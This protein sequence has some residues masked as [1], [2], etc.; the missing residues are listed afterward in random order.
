MKGISPQIIPVVFQAMMHQC[1]EGYD[2]EQWLEEHGVRSR[3]SPQEIWLL[4]CP[5]CGH[6]TYYDRTETAQCA[7]CGYGNLRENHEN[8]YRLIDLWDLQWED[9][10]F[11]RVH[12]RRA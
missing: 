3:F 9:E 4:D 2:V 1:S 5:L 8:A 12:G 10:D 6:V 7:C 11:Y